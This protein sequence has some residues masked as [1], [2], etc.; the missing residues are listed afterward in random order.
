VSRVDRRAQ[1]LPE[2][3]EVLLLELRRR[4]RGEAEDVLGRELVLLEVGLALRRD[5]RT[6]RR[7]LLERL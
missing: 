2:E 3:L 5:V 1:D 7:D 4:R 6:L